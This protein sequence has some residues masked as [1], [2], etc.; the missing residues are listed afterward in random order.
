MGSGDGGR[1]QSRF[2]TVRHLDIT[3]KEFENGGFT[4]KTHQMVSVHVSPEEL[5]NT[6]ITSH[7][8][9]EFDENSRREITLLS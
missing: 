5:K 2:V 4:L 6:T 3:P 8:G 9:F 1:W 7:Y